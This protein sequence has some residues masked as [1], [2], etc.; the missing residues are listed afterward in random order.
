MSC[1]FS[2]KKQ[3]N[4]CDSDSVKSP[5]V[6]SSSNCELTDLCAGGICEIPQQSSVP[7]MNL[8]ELYLES[9]LILNIFQ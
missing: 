7:C 8:F 1:N 6:S 4:S 2:V 3:C 5:Q 9:N